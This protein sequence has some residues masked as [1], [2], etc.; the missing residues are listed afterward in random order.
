MTANS[1]RPSLSMT[2][3][4]P[5]RVL[6]SP[7][8]VHKDTCMVLIRPRS[9]HRS[10]RRHLELPGKAWSTWTTV[11]VLKSPQGTIN[12][13]P[14][15]PPWYK[16]AIIGAGVAGLRTAML[17]QS[18]SIPYKIFEASERPGGR[19]FTYQFASK[20][21]NDPQGRHDYYDVGAMRFPNNN[22]NKRTFE[23]FKQ[24]GV[25]RNLIPYV[26]SQDD[27]FLIFN[28][29][30]TTAAAAKTQGNHFLDD[31]PQQYTDKVYRD[32]WGRTVYGLQACINEA[33]DP[34]REPLIKNFKQGWQNLMT[35]DWAS[36][37]SYLTREAPNYPNY[38]L[39]VVQWMETRDGGTGGYDRAFSE[40]V[41][42]SLEFDDPTQEATGGVKW[43]CLEGGSRV[44]IDGFLAN[45]STQPSYGQ[46]VT[47]VEQVYVY[48]AD[49]FPD[50]PH[51][52][53][54]W[55]RFPFMKVSVEGQGDEYFC[56]V[57]STASFAALRTINTEDVFMSYWQRQAIRTL[58]YGPATKVGIKF[59]T[60]WWEQNGQKQ[61][62]G[63]SYTDRP[64][65]V[66]VYPSYGLGESG[67]GVLMATYNWQQDA[68]RFGALIQNPDWSQQLVPGRDP[69]WSEKILLDQIYADIATIHGVDE[70]VLRADTLDYHPYD[71][72]HNP[73]T[74]GAFAFF[75][76]GQFRLLFPSIVQPAS[77]GRFHFAG[78]VA[79]HHHAWVAGALDSAERVV[80]EILLLDFP[81]WV[82]FFNKTYGG[83]LVF[84][85]EKRAEAQFVKGLYARELERATSGPVVAGG[86]QVGGG[87][88]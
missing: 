73:Y 65:R 15:I 68:S 8:L 13:F 36:T 31:I 71:W 2:S 44:M 37:R 79:S 34:F 47:S 58:A 39:S 55:P 50:L 43:W 88:A 26:F 7:S 59:K 29:I 3:Q 18:L 28:G 45:L 12:L 81:P 19:I 56:H 75:K 62:G 6:I 63:S 52:T 60:R 74:M 10:F 77:Y 21:P 27:N 84:S 83:S 25:S 35:Y 49:V 41:L 38:P 5:R 78:E 48:P 57:V 30:Q 20:P 46:R 14:V 22:A 87:R 69:P 82:P 32:P 33:L 42:E 40:T 76:P 85:D 64:I 80:K 24:L 72:Y 4:L 54:P 1:Y 16:V 11:V 53:P 9:R 61:F 86:G 17:L 51:R 66:A 67:P 70:R 23:L